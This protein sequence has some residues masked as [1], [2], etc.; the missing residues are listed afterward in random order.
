M[1]LIMKEGFP[2]HRVS[3]D[4]NNSYA[5]P[6]AYYTSQAVYDAEIEKIFFKSWILAGHISKLARKGDYI[7]LDVHGQS[8]LVVRETEGVLR[9]FYN[10]CKHRAH[11]LLKGEGRALVVTCPAHG[12]SY[13][14][15]GRLRS[16]PGLNQV[17]NFSVSDVCLTQVR[18]EEFC[19]LVFINL[20]MDAPSLEGQVEGLKEKVLSYVPNPEKLVLAHRRVRPANTNWKNVV[21]NYL[22]CYHCKSTHKKF[23]ELVDMDGYTTVPHGNWSWH[24]GPGF[25]QPGE[26]HSGEVNEGFAGA[27]LWPNLT[28]NFFPGRSEELMLYYTVPTSPNTSMGVMEFYMANAELSEEAKAVIDWVTNVLT[29]ED[30]ALCESVQVGMRS[31]G[32]TD[33]RLVVNTE[34]SYLSEHSLHYFHNKILKALGVK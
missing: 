33:G 13:G 21:D 11:T 17:Q 30:I 18:V 23:C 29:E 24:S 6:A 16:G 26:E 10:V 8:I 3:D 4:P 14:L 9:A 22:E 27:H 25:P 12:W 5:L 7:T 2:A 19:G 31:K 15:D 1:N 28:I 34:R 20:D 32:Y